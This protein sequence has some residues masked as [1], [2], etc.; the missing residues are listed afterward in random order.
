[1]KSFDSPVKKINKPE[2][3]CSGKHAE[4]FE[5]SQQTREHLPRVGENKP[6]GGILHHKHHKT[7]N[8]LLPKSPS[9]TETALC[10]SSSSPGPLSVSWQALYSSVMLLLSIQN[11]GTFFFILPDVIL[12][13]PL[14]R[15]LYQLSVSSENS[16]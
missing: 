1:M 6:H 11:T 8:S 7:T 9:A 5:L 14:C 12:K 10:F 3:S 4:S 13:L 16:I 15:Q 2:A